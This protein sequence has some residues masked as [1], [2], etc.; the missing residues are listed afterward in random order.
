[1][2]FFERY[3]G[4]G[5]IFMELFDAVDREE[6]ILGFDL[7]RGKNIPAGVY[8]RI[9]EIFTINERMEILLT[10][11]DRKKM[12]GGLWE[13]TGGAVIKGETPAAGALRELQ[14]ET[15]LHVDQADLHMIASTYSEG[16]PSGIYKT[17]GVFVDMTKQQIHLQAEETIDFRF[18]S[19]EEFL[20]FIETDQYVPSLRDRFH[21]Y[22]KSF[23]QFMEKM[24]VKK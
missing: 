4:T 15:G 13:I 19:Y 18:V 16:D 20:T 12:W 22:R 1:M 6:K 21:L 23:E 8:H 2:T 9:V 5:G 17:Y 14:E 7:E 10:K 3:C 11:R 24:Q